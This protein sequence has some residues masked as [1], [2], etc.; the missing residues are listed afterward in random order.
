MIVQDDTL[1]TVALLADIARAED[2]R[3]FPENSVAGG[4]PGLYSW[5]ADSEAI[6][7]F[8]Q[9]VGTVSPEQC[10]YIGQTGGTKWPSGTRSNATLRDRILRNHVR[11]NVSSSTFRWTISAI[12]FKPLK[13]QLAKPKRLCLEDN[14]KVSAWIK[15]HLRVSIVP[16]P[17]RDSLIGVEEDVLV[18]LDPPLNLDGCP[19]NDLRCRLTKL[20]KRLT[21]LDEQ[22]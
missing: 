9:T 7:L 11:G 2:P 22:D 10:I 16:Y 8:A 20:R 6:D 13:L 12:L 1:R 19:T 17:D 3:R 5:W 21:V 14:R 15:D 18:N 4:S